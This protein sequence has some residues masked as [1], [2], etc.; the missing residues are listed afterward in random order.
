ML[1]E[2]R[3]VDDRLVYVDSDTRSLSLTGGST[4]YCSLKQELMARLGLYEDGQVADVEVD[5]EYRVDPEAGELV[6]TNRI[7]LD[8]VAWLEELPTEE[9]VGLK[10][11]AP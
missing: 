6:V 2:P 5:Q 8:G 9:R 10:Q 11:S 3:I 7:D 1:L 4:P